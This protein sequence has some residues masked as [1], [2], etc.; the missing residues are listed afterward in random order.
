MPWLILLGLAAA[1]TWYVVH[2]NAAAAAAPGK[3]VS[4]TALLIGHWY[5]VTVMVTPA[6]VTL[7]SSQGTTPTAG[8][9]VLLTGEAKAQGF[10]GALAVLVKQNTDAS[11]AATLTGPYVGGQGG[12]ASTANMS[13]LQVEE[14]NAPA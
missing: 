12:I 9:T 8:L 3:V 2:K 7:A 14:V 10:A 13:V 6:A 4:P 5:R 11:Y 1:G